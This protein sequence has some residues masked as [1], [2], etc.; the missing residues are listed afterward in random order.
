MRIRTILIGI[1]VIVVGLFVTGYA[2]LKSLDLNDYKDVL[3]EQVKQATGRDVTV[4]G[5]IELEVSFTPRLAV[6]DVTFSNAEWGTRPEMIKLERLEAVVDL[7][8]LLSSEVRVNR[9][10]MV[11][12]DVLLETDAEGNPNW[13]FPSASDGDTAATGSDGTEYQ[14][15]VDEVSVERA[16]ITYRDGRTGETQTV[17]IDNLSAAA[18]SAAVPIVLALAGSLNDSPVTVDGTIPSFNELQAGGEMP[19]DLKIQGGGAAVTAKGVVSAAAFDVTVTAAGQSLAD[20]GALA[21]AELPAIGPYTLSAIVT[22]PDGAYQLGDF[23]LKMADSTLSGT[24]SIALDGPRPKLVA[25][26]QSTR[27]DLADFGVEPAPTADEAATT[28]EGGD[29]GRIFP[30]DPLPLDGLQLADATVRFT[31]IEVIREPQTLKNVA[32]DIVLENGRLTMNN[33]GADLAGGKL[34]VSGI[35]DSSQ[36]PAGISLKL[37]SNQIE[38]G[39]LLQT[40][41]ETPIFTGGTVNLDVDVAGS[42]NSVR[43]IMASLGGTTN[44][45]MGQGKID[46]TFAKILLSDL[47][48]LIVSGGADGS[49]LNCVVSRFSITGGV[50]EST[51]LVID[52]NGATILGTGTVDLRDEKPDIGLVPHAK[53]TNL[54]NIAIPVRIRGTLADP[55]VAPDPGAMATGLVSTVG[56]IGTGV[57]D[58]LASV[59]GNGTS[60]SAD[61]SG[62]NACVTALA[63]PAAEQPQSSGEKI[64]EGAEQMLDGA[65]QAG[66]GI[67][68]GAGELLDDAGSAIE[69]LFGN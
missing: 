43:E 30:D 40:L 11:G 13:A 35:I 23:T 27:L 20:L 38:A 1:V 67:G 62:G 4:G 46:N 51:A 56:G 32:V 33:I 42:G 64:T 44:F 29:D 22:N 59:T 49:N 47:F 36:N 8:P 63:S 26:L 18:D 58:A 2:I 3:A 69:G 55:S 28:P 41:G 7:I 17:A 65:G 52:T 66:E 54:A 31:G 19:I 25:D 45:E 14:I 10:V 50:A 61:S 48:Q 16:L 39:S 57:F 37:V 60:G 53:Q 5:N 68:Q 21:G 6:N 34:T 9:F 15:S 24:A 12:A